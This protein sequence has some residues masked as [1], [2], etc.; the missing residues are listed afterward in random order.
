MWSVGF[1]R[2]VTIASIV[3]IP[4]AVRPYVQIRIE[5]YDSFMVMGRVRRV[6]SC[7]VDK[8]LATK[9]EWLEWSLQTRKC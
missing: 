7:G 9:S 5:F 3:Y 4:G 2:T 8:R 1:H 6:C